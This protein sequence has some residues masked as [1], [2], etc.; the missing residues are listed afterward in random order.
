M[1]I[2]GVIFVVLYLALI[3]LMIVGQWKMFVKAG[4]PGWASIVPIYNFIVF[5]A[6]VG[7]PW[8][9]LFLCIVPFVNIVIWIILCIDLAKCH[10]KRHVS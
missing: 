3:V 8:W 2:A 7:K 9:W 1:E 5:L 6:I 10:E 4:Q